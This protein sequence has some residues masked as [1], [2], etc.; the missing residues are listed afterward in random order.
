MVLAELGGKLRDSLRRL[1]PQPTNEHVQQTL[2]DISRALM[3]ADVN[4]KLV[5]TLRENIKRRIEQLPSEKKITPRLVQRAVVDELTALLHPASSTPPF[6]PRRGQSNVICLVGLQGAGKTTT[7]AKLA[8]Y[9]LKRKWKVAMVCADTFCAGALDPLKPNYD[10]PFTAPTNKSIP[11]S[12]L[13]R[14]FR[15]FSRQNNTKL[16]LL[17]HWGGTHK[18]RPCCRN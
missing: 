5:F 10:C 13:P 2:S 11:S 14:V 7:I 3:E 16:F 12:L 15:N 6:S 18:K 1:P 4:V 8:Q 17:T 9:Y